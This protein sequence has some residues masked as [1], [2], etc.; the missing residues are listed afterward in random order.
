MLSENRKQMEIAKNVF[1]AMKDDMDNS[2]RETVFEI[3]Y[4]SDEE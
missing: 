1:E 4:G 2:T 3:V